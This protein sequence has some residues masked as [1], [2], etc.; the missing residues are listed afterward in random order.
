VHEFFDLPNLSAAL[1]REVYSTSN[2]NELQTRKIMF[3]GSRALSV[4]KAD[5]IT[6]ICECGILNISRP[7]GLLR[8]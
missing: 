8:G 1:G 5:N 6:A 2:R 7:Y 3:Q 4:R